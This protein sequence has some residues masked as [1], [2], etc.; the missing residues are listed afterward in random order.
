MKRPVA[1]ITGGAGFIGHYLVEEFYK[2]HD[3]ICLIRPGTKNLKRIYEICNLN[4]Q[5]GWSSDGYWVQSFTG[6]TLVSKDLRTPIDLE[7]LSR[8]VEVDRIKLILH[9]GGNPSSESSILDPISVVLDN[10]VGTVNMLEVAK[11][12]Q[13]DRFVYYGAAESYGPVA[14]DEVSRETDPY[15]SISPYAASKSS[16][17]E[18]CMAYYKTY[19]VPVSVI[20]IAN[21]FGPRCQTNRYPVVLINNIL[22]GK[23]TTILRSK[24]GK[25]GG[26]RWFHAQD[27]ADITRFV[28]QHQT[29]K[30]DKWNAAGQRFVDNF[31]LGNIVSNILGKPFPYEYGVI[32]RNGHEAHMSITPQKLF[33]AGWVPKYHLERRLED[34]VYWYLKHREWL[35]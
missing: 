33:D 16:G 7:L 25:V 24:D 1:I 2:T 9:A 5:V 11:K 34:T 17:A 18:F 23:T 30:F 19:G 26:R 21:T 14:E 15:N 35:V 12:L 10:V 13:I 4:E 3:L 6:I 31:Y 27:V 8:V 28:L 29:E 20:N 22:E 32:R